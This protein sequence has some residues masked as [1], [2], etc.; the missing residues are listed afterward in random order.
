MASVPANRL[1][2]AWYDA[3][4]PDFL[5]ATPDSI[6]GALTRGSGDHA[7]EPA[8]AQAW[9]AEIALLK[10]WLAPCRAGAVFLEFT[11]PRMGRRIDAVL[12]LGGVVVVIEFKVGQARIERS[13]LDQAWD[14]ALD[15]KNFH[16]ASHGRAIVPIL[17]ATESESRSDLFSLDFAA[18]QVARPVAVPAGAMCAMLAR[19][20][21]LRPAVSD[22]TVASQDAAAWSAAPYRPTPTIVEA[23]R[24]LYAQHSVHAIA[25]H[26]AGATNLHLTSQRLESLVEEAR[27]RRR[28][29]LCFVTG[30]PGAGKTLVGLNL[31]TQH[32]EASEKGDGFIFGSPKINPSPFSPASHAVFLSG[33]GPLVAV[34]RE[35]LTRD[36][37]E[38][39]KARCE[40]ISKANAG[41][42]VKAF[43]QNV[44]HFR[45]EALRHPGP[46]ADHVVIFDEAQRAWNRAKAANFMKQRKGI[47]DFAHS[48]PEFLIQ[49]MDRHTDW[50]VIVCLVGG[51]QEIHTGEAGIAEW[52]QAATTH[53]PH[54]HLHVSSQLVDGEYAAG[55]ALELIR[56]RPNV[57]LDEQA[58][59]LHVSMRSFRAERVSAFVKALLDCDR[60]GAA[61]AYQSFKDRY[62]IVITR[63]LDKAKAWVRERARGNEQ[64]G[65]LASS[66]AMRLKPYAIDI[67]VSVDPVQWF[68]N[69]RTD[70]R[71]SWYL[72]DCATEFQVQGL[73]LDWACV[74]W[75]GDFRAKAP[76]EGS[77]WSCHDFRGD[78]WVN[79]HSPDNRNYLKNAYR[80]LLTR[81]RQGMVVF[82]PPGDSADPTRLPSHY[83]ETWRY[84]RAAGI[85]A[86]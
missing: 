7:V 33:N 43:I 28:K 24:A 15:L 78:R 76:A 11:I 79:I 73:E 83:D 37:V 2:R 59:H 81:A 44:H 51:G 80:V 10:S 65:L 69:D 60:E 85:K 74:T 63:D 26:D 47:P 48:E 49:Y 75:D 64:Y 16:E 86:L 62:P 84:L 66:K 54:W 39:R 3:A 77:G 67:R 55:H 4:I 20:Q 46:P 18:D 23:A 36:D 5:A 9:L 25:R 38:R 50:A 82:V 30:V 29:I 22:P 58:L 45:D 35:A 56:T 14:Y 61:A 40:R 21:A 19:L 53:F 17:V 41:K 32:R 52:L 1:P 57:H 27:T 31:A 8:Q 12:L 70:V 71:S 68:L 6:L 34:L 13:A 72:E 42:P